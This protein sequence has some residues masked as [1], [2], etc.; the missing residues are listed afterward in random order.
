M[1]WLILLPM[2]LVGCAEVV[3]EAEMRTVMTSDDLM[4]QATPPNDTDENDT[5][6]PEPFHD[7]IDLEVKTPEQASQRDVA[8]EFCIAECKD[9][10]DGGIDI[11][12]GPCLSNA[13]IDGW[14]CDVAHEPRIP[15][16]DENECGA[17]IDQIVNDFVV[18]DTECDLIRVS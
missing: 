4:P 15:A 17:Y 9:M 1:R 18:L 12:H 6:I 11:S 2:L 5:E 8:I 10:L 14:I 3:E 7:G 13:I 16:D